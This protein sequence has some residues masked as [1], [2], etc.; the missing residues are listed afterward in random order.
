VPWR[1]CKTPRHLN[2][3]ILSN[4][5]IFK[6]RHSMRPFSGLWFILFFVLVLTIFVGIT[7]SDW[8]G[9]VAALIVCCV[10]IPVLIA[11]NMRYR[12]W[13]SDGDTLHMQA[14]TWNNRAN[15]TSIKISEITSISLETSNVQTA[16]ALRRPF[17]RLAI[18]SE[19][20]GQT[21]WIDV[22]LK[23][24]VKSDIQKLLDIIKSKRP[25]LTIPTL[26]V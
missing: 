26:R 14:S 10:C 18:Y 19:R 4:M 12:V 2:A 13:L 6:L 11:F 25:D 24:F 16:A 5:Q 1:P 21:K 15:T 7:N 8:G 3:D 20:H 9:F 23:H 17:R 22:S